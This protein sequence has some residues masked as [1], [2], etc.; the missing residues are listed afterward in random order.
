[1][2]YSQIQNYDFFTPLRDDQVGESLQMNLN[3][4]PKDTFT[5]DEVTGEN[6]E[7]LLDQISFYNEVDTGITLQQFV[8]T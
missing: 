4:M 7:R 8:T 6:L 2:L 5:Y 3:L 1:M